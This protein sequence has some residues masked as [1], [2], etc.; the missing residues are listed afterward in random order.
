MKKKTIDH[1]HISNHY[2]KPR[3]QPW[4]RGY[5]D[6]S[7]ETPNGKFS[8]PYNAAHAIRKEREAENH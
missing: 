6:A 2:G 5:D 4:E 1:R 8:S 7:G 3:A